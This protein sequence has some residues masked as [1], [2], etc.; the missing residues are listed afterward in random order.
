MIDPKNQNYDPEAATFVP[1]GS[2]GASPTRT[3]NA[4]QTPLPSSPPGGSEAPTML[5][6]ALP[7]MAP[8]T[9]Q[10][11]PPA[12]VTPGSPS[13]S[14]L[15]Q[16]GILLGNRYQIIH[17]LGEGGMGAVYKAKDIELDRVIALKVIRPELASNPEI[18]Q[19]FKQELILARQ[20]TDR[21]VIRIFD[22]GEANGIRFIT[23]EYVEGESLYHILR[24]QGK[25]PVNEAVEMMR[26][27]LSG[28][29]AAHRE[30]VIHRDLKPGNIMRDSQGR[31][32]VMDFGLA[33]SLE[34]GGMTLTGTMMGTLEYMSPEQAQAKQVDARS[35]IFTVGLI[36]YE[37]L[38]G[39]TPFHA[40]SAI[41]SLVRRTS[42]RAI[43]VSDHDGTIPTSLSNIVSKCLERDPNLRYQNAG[44]VLRDIE[45]WQGNH[46]G[47]TLGFQPAVEPW[48]RTIHWPLLTGI[49]TVLLLALL[50]YAFRGKL[51]TRSKPKGVTTSAVSLAILPFRNASGDPA[52]DWLGPSLAD[53]L[54]T[55]VGQSARLRTIS[56]D[57]LHQVLGDLRVTP[58]TAIDPTMVG[59]IAEFSSADTVVWGQY[60]KFGDQIRV[61]ATLQDLKHDRRVALK[62]EGASEKDIPGAVDRLAETIRQN[63]ALSPDILKELK[64][65][66][67]QPTSTS[68]E[69][70]REYNQGVALVRDGKN[71]EAEK[72]LEMAVQ[73][74]PSFALAFSKLAQTY[75]SLGYDDRAEQAARKAV[76]LSD[77]LPQAEK[78]VISAIQARVSKD[79]SRAIA[80][81]TELA[82]AAPDNSDVQFALGSLYED[83]GDFTKATAHFKKLLDTNPN[84]MS[85]VLATGRVAIKSGNPQASLDPLSHALSLAIQVDN[86]EQKALIL[87]AMGIAY[88]NLNKPE[89]ALQNYQQSL[90]IKRRLGQRKGMAD[91][92]NMIAETYDGL[93][94]SQLALA[95]YNEALKGYREIGDR[96]DIGNVLLNL[97]QF[98]HDRGKYND[99][100]KLFM[101]SLQIQREV[102]DENYQALCLNNI[103]NSHLFKGDFDDARTYFERALQ[104]R[105]K[106]KVPSDIADTLHNLGEVSMKMGQYDQALS[107]Y[108][109]AL[110]L[111]REAADKEGAAKESESMGTLFSYQGRYGAALKARQD[112]MNGFRELQDRSYWM[113]ETLG[114]YGNSL[115]QVGRYD[116]ADKNLNE[117]LSLARELK[118]EAL[119]AE[120]MTWQGENLAYQGD[121]KSA[122]NL[123]IQASQIASKTSDRDLQIALKLKLAGMS[124]PT[125][126]SKK[127]I[128]D[129]QVLADQAA[130]MGF[131]DT[132]TEASLAAVDA[133]IRAKDYATARQ[134]L[135][136]LL[137]STEK[138]GAQPLLAKIHLL[139][140]EVLRLSGKQADATIEYRQTIQIVEGMRKESGDKFT[141]RADIKAMSAEATRWAA[142]QF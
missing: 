90:E 69:A 58:G 88:T 138:L 82:K 33:R 84:D 8:V 74:D 38:A 31:I 71:L 83:T 91:S 139:R 62:I 111:R 45:A 43:P 89:E 42:E 133:M 79:Y 28:L 18:L 51:S 106:I 19:R 10:N 17:M 81:Y 85:A 134:T 12:A 25:V 97:G 107:H 53:M 132:S 119:T 130:T 59:R 110:D 52:I 15:L 78:Y 100:L 125:A 137:A 116:E 1:G 60:A 29:Q 20:V 103:G 87:Q 70:L 11:P 117:A 64:A 2:S 46:A 7:R 115:S 126:P 48:G 14:A 63:L 112:A 121:A 75:S 93:G 135:E 54:S 96:R 9:R 3:G 80:A 40:D 140:G 39:V 136:N 73:E 24:R 26:Q 129:F 86:Q 30:G 142:S 36:C 41:A 32:V 131:K 22:L 76:D 47:A 49:A 102:G 66:S 4:V 67:F 35:D 101:E 77:S 120:I 123:Y 68:V 141:D 109:K 128:A 34:G 23:M 13:A 6:G 122:K 27:M 113:A 127:A 105:E 72:R 98:Y 5:E 108:L 118:N 99:A 44:E 61:D 94:K 124:L 92:L 65:S 55:D 114:G 56:P 50:L 57:R 37:L 16:P 104:L 95:S 21:N